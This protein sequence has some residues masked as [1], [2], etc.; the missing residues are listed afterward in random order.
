MALPPVAARAPVPEA[1]TWP[2]AD[3]TATETGTLPVTVGA[4]SGMTAETTWPA[5]NFPL[6]LAVAPRL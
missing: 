3:S 1:R 4:V 2:G 6:K 5:A